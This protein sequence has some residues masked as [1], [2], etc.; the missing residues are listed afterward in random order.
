MVID[1][2]PADTVA[3]AFPDICVRPIEPARHTPWGGPPG[4]APLALME[5]RD[6]DEVVQIVRF[7]GERRIAIVPQGGLTG[8]AGGAMPSR[9]GAEIA[10]S[11]RR[12]AR[13]RDLDP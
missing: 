13:I 9:A 1:R 11:L 4:P 10:V 2:N 8:L 6:L 7:A 3:R 12:M 5:P